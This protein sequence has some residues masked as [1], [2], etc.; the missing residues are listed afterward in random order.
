MN[1]FWSSDSLKKKITPW[2]TISFLFSQLLW[3]HSP[4][5]YIHFRNFLWKIFRVP[6][7]S[8]I[9]KKPASTFFFSFFFPS[10]QSNPQFPSV[11]TSV[12]SQ[13][14][15]SGEPQLAPWWTLAG[16]RAQL[17]TPLVSPAPQNLVDSIF[18]QNI[19][20]VLPSHHAMSATAAPAMPRPP[21]GSTVTRKGVN[22]APSTTM[23][24]MPTGRV[25]WF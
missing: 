13:S 12:R 2:H 18:F 10:I 22:E 15:S 23:G 3:T 9:K 4:G 6:P 25:K 11:I 5:S 20:S 24:A 21:L 17:F 8:F 1:P 16:A 14:E 7:L 19:P